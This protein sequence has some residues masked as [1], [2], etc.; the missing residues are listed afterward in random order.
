[1]DHQ[2]VLL[3]LPRFLVEALD[4]AASNN[5]RSRTAEVTARLEKSFEGEHGVILAP[6]PTR[7]K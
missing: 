5:Y 1:M 4:V 2:Q 6:Q 3:R 7:R